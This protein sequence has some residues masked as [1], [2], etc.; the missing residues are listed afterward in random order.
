MGIPELGT[1][2]YAEKLMEELAAT[3]KAGISDQ[4]ALLLAQALRVS[5]SDLFPMVK[6][7]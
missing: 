1:Q 6:H 3:I 4:E 2:A 7:R 5:V